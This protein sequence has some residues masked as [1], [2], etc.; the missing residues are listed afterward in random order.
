MAF[1]EGDYVIQEIPAATLHP[2]LCDTVLPGTPERGP[3]WL[4][5]H[6]S[7]SSHNLGTEFGIAIEDQ[8]L[9]RGFIRECFAQLLHH[10]SALRV[11][12]HIEVQNSPTVVRNHKKAVQ[13]AQ[14]EGRDREEVHRSYDFAM[15]PQESP[16]TLC[17]FRF[18]GGVSYPT[19]NG[20]LR[21]LEAEH[22]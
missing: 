7:D 12:G 8:V 10:P 18:S 3:G 20:S 9:G 14:R 17:G 2:A 1:I 4:A 6:G 11:R 21:N 19:R 22:L 13:Y 16:P 15:V 5:A